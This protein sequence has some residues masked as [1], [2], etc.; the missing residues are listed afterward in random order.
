MDLTYWRENKFYVNPCI[1]CTN[2][3]LFCVRNFQDGVYGFNLASERNPTPEEVRNAVE[4]TWNGIFTDAAIVGFGEPLLNLKASLEAI[5]TI[6]RLSDIPVRMDTNGQASLIHPRRDV[7]AELK[8]AGLE[9]I[10]ISLN[11][12]SA[13]VYDALCQSEF[14]L[15][16]YESVLQFARSCKGLMRVVL[17][18]VDIPGV[19]IEACRRVADELQVN[20][21]VR[22]FKG[23]PAVADSISQK[24]NKS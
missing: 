1:E 21:R 24:L 14:G 15:P 3:C 17:S 12:S 16:A 13:E 20:L 6:K 22:G 7:A 10:Q 4:N 18:V 5:R 2:D 8:N 23:P 19:D 9:E 11:A